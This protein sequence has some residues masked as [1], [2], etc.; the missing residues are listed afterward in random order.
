M[1]PLNAA[2]CYLTFNNSTNINMAS[3][4]ISPKEGLNSDGQQFHQYQQNKHPSLTS[5]N[6]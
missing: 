3:T 4:H 6:D 1:S 5:N 2:I